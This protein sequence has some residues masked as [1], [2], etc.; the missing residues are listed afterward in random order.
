MLAADKHSN[1]IA[2]VDI[3]AEVDIAV[4]VSA[5]AD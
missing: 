1:H 5:F 4:A 2:A 3:V